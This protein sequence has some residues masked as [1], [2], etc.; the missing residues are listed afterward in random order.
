MHQYYQC[1]S[2][3]CQLFVDLFISLYNEV[4]TLQNAKFHNQK[5]KAPNIYALYGSQNKQILL[6]CMILPYWFL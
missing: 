2:F 4:V 1:I 6:P 5:H 3:K